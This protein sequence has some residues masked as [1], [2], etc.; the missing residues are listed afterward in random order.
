MN[1]HARL[2]KLKLLW[3]FVLFALIPMV[4]IAV[5]SYYNIKNQLITSQLSHL[6]AIAKLKSLQ[7][8]NFY[9]ESK[10]D[11][12]TISSLPYT[13]EILYTNTQSRHY[14]EV[15]NLYEQ[16][17]NGFVLNHGINNVYIIAL[18]GKIVASAP[19]SKENKFSSFHK[20]AFEEGKTKIFFSLLYKKSTPISATSQHHN[21]CLI[22]STPI[23]G[24]DNKLLG[25]IVAEFSVNKLFVLL[26]DYSGLG[27]SGETLLGKRNNEKIIFLNPLRHDPSAGM[28]R[29]VQI[30]GKIAIP[31][32]LGVTGHNG[33][34]LSV[35]YRGVSVLAAWRHVPIADWGMVAKID[36]DEALKPLVPIQDS[37]IFTALFILILSI[38]I[39]FKMTDDLI[40]PVEHL[41]TDAHIDFLTG[42][43]NR[44]LLMGSLEEVIKKAKT[45]GSIIAVMFL[46]LDGFKSVNDTFGHEIGDL[47][48]QNVAQRLINCVRQSDTVAR[49]GGDEFII[50]LYGRLDMNNIVKIANTIIQKL[51]EDFFINNTKINIGVSIGIS[52]FPDNTTNP[53]EML[54]LADNAMYEAKHHGKNNYKFVNDL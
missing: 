30:N 38:A 19:Q 35:D 18:D 4:L 16:E 20:L 2:L 33:S 6:E 8:E 22:V 39:S 24:I 12:K 37:I 54:R 27:S 45:K 53:D 7:I 25:V 41:E 47:L 11:I 31:V 46:D 49:L 17:L 28:Q 40:L 9:S 3:L 32:I 26:Q 10:N 29:S 5:Y 34:G 44:K 36:T 48:L 50:L 15:K 52:L 21:Y 1:G 23:F 43:P 51:N 14:N 13:K 42:L